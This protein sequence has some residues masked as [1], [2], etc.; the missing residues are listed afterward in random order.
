MK[1]LF[2]GW[3]LPI[4]RTRRSS[5]RLCQVF[6]CWAVLI[7]AQAAPVDFRRD[8]HPL[9]KQYCVE[10]HG[11]NQQMGGLRLDR[12]REAMKG[13]ASVVI[14]PGS[15]ASSKLYLRLIGNYGMRM[16]PTAPLKPEQIRIIQAWIDQGAEWPDD[17][18]GEAPPRP[19]DPGAA[20]VMEALRM[21]DHNAFRKLLKADPKASTRRGP[22]GATPLM[23]AALYADSSTLR[24]LLEAGA[25]ANARNDGGATALMWAVPDFEKTKLLVDHGAHV[26]ARSEDG[27]TP[28]LIA[29]S[30]RNS[31]PVL[32]LLL[33]RGATPNVKSAGGAGTPLAEAAAVGDESSIRTLI[34]A[35]AELTDL[36]QAIGYALWSRCMKCVAAMAKALRPSDLGF[37]LGHLA[38]IGDEDAVR[39]LLKHGAEAN[40]PAWPG[41]PTALTFAGASDAQPVGIAR[42]LLDHGSDVNAKTS[43][44]QTALY[45]ARRRGDTPLVK[46]LLEA[47]AKEERD[48]AA[49]IPAAPAISARAAIERSLPLLQRTDVTFLRKSGCVSCH[50]NTLTAVSV[51]YARRKGI[52]VDEGAARKQT[53]GIAAY[54]DNLR[55]RL[56]QNDGNPGG[57]G[58]WSHLLLGLAAQGHR[59]DAATDAAARFLANRQVEEGYWRIA[60]H[61]PPLEASDIEVTAVSLRALQVYAPMAQRVHYDK[62]IQLAAAW[63]TTAHPT[64]TEDR[65]FQLLGLTWARTGKDELRKAA[66]EFISEQRADGGWAQLPTLS[67]DAYATG[68]AL[69]ALMESGT[70][71]ANSEVFERGSKFLLNT[72]LA[73]GSWYVQSRSFPFQPY[74]ESGFPHGHDQWISAAATNWATMAMTFAVQ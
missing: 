62:R 2:L 31:T 6:A 64:T 66:R 15:S 45:F 65:T 28:L 41:G 11:P 46:L 35:G 24:L 53:A 17:L 21:G 59:P 39:L 37:A 54:V 58:G 43:D 67:S 4:T 23:Y 34:E 68:Q 8:V 14:G 52:S 69:T 10:C 29:S 13:G 48:A 33:A 22:G 1:W 5:G 7:C 9:L 49:V 32:K 40:A 27:R 26:D 57:A 16:P 42:M 71:S 60:E 56:L 12:R 55:D 19:V 36:G 72:Q 30:W 73:D 61:R 25:D 20:R 18:S 74:F 44:G 47:G 51:A 38:R 50:N 70:I 3:P 63:L